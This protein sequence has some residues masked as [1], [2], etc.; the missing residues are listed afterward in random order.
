[1]DEILISLIV[2]TRGRVEGMLAFL[3]SVR[4]HAAC[5]QNIEVVVVVDA[6]D[7]AS[8]AISFEGLSLLRSSC[9]PA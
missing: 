7:P 5:P 2:P 6:D 3:E 4:A 8:Q 1:M 9:L